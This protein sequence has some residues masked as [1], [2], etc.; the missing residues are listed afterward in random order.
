LE[1]ILRGVIE[2]LNM[3]ERKVKDLEGH[4]YSLRIRPYHTSDNRIDGA[5]ITLIDIDESKHRAD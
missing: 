1:N 5:V 2:T 3:F 4:D